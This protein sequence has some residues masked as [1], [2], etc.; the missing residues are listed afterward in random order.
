MGEKEKI[1]IDPPAKKSQEI[2]PDIKVRKDYEE[3]SA[4]TMSKESDEDLID[5]LEK[6]IGGD[7]YFNI[8]LEPI[9][10]KLSK[11]REYIIYL[12]IIAKSIPYGERE[13]FFH[14][15][16]PKMLDKFKNDKI[17]PDLIEFIKSFRERISS[18]DWNIIKKE[19][20]DKKLRK[21]LIQMAKDAT[22]NAYYLF[23]NLFE[24]LKDKFN[25][26]GYA[27]IKKTWLAGGNLQKHFKDYDF[28]PSYLSL[29]LN[30][31]KDDSL[32]PDLVRI[33]TAF[34]KDSNYFK[35]Q[36]TEILKHFNDSGFR[37]DLVKLIEL[38]GN[39]A[40]NIVEQFKYSSVS[41]VLLN[42][43][44]R[45]KAL[46]ITESLKDGYFVCSNFD[47]LEGVFA[48]AE[49]AQ[50]FLY[51]YGM[52]DSENRSFFFQKFNDCMLEDFKDAKFRKDI[53][54]MIEA[55]PKLAAYLVTST[56]PIIREKFKE[57]GYE[58][59]KKYWDDA[60]KIFQSLGKDVDN[61]ITRRYKGGPDIRSTFINGSSSNKIYFFSKTFEKDFLDDKSR[62]TLVKISEDLKEKSIR[63]FYESYET[64]RKGGMEELLSTV[65]HIKAILDQIDNNNRQ[66]TLESHSLNYSFGGRREEFNQEAYLSEISEASKILKIK[67]SNIFVLIE[68]FVGNKNTKLLDVLNN[69]YLKGNKDV[70]PF[71]AIYRAV[72]LVDRNKASSLIEL[73]GLEKFVSKYRDLPIKDKYLMVVQVAHQFQA[74]KV[75]LLESIDLTEE[76]IGKAFEEEKNGGG[77]KLNKVYYLILSAKLIGSEKLTKEIKSSI[78]FED[79]A[80]EKLSIEIF[81]LLDEFDFTDEQK[82]TLLK[83]FSIDI[84]DVNVLEDMRKRLTKISPGKADQFI[85]DKAKG[86]IEESVGKNNLEEKVR[87]VANWSSF[88]IGDKYTNDIYIYAANRM[89]DVIKRYCEKHECP[90]YAKWEIFDEKELKEIQIYQEKILEEKR[91]ELEEIR[92]ME[93]QKKEDSIEPLADWVLNTSVSPE[94]ASRINNTADLNVNLSLYMRFEEEGLEEQMDFI[95]EK[96][97]NYINRNQESLLT[98]IEWR[99]DKKTLKDV[100][101]DLQIHLFESKSGLTAKAKKIT[102][103]VSDP[104]Y[105]VNRGLQ[106]IKGAEELK[107]EMKL[108]KELHFS[109]EY[110]AKT[111]EYSSQAVRLKEDEMHDC[112]TP[113]TV[114]RGG[115]VEAIILKLDPKKGAK[116][117]FLVQVGSTSKGNIENILKNKHGNNLIADPVGAMVH[118]TDIPITM[119]FENGKPLNKKTTISGQR[120]GMVVFNQS[121]DMVILKKSEIHYSQLNKVAG[122]ASFEK[123]LENQIKDLE[124]EFLVRFKGEKI[125]P[126]I[127]LGENPDAMNEYKKL[128]EVRELFSEWKNGKPLNYASESSYLPQTLFWMIVRNSNLSGFIESLYVEDG[129]NMVKE[130]S[131][132]AHK[133]LL[134][135]FSDGTFGL[136]D[137]R[138][139]MQDDEV[140]EK[141]TQI[142]IDGV[143]VVKAVNLDTGSADNTRIYDKN[144]NSYQTGMTGNTIV[145]NR[146][147]IY[148]K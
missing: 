76:V 135:E 146:I 147:G 83:Q 99:G 22:P 52:I 34:D 6:E 111:K 148:Q 87:F 73:F 109:S 69:Y 122:L 2:Q 26:E 57:E 95:K 4:E 91:R 132:A 17:R 105:T 127:L 11:K 46:K 35:E 19:F 14:D 16:F 133:R 77:M 137:S 96:I 94:L 41:N 15:Q 39:N 82:I 12:T 74:K 89:K 79:V 33:L 142:K 117:D 139:A 32:S 143:K 116:F 13:S 81:S 93:N 53:I 101:P 130:R 128:F 40:N 45:T 30:E 113:Y 65:K 62:E 43:E 100:L 61:F 42:T 103:I 84:F 71:L 86:F 48:D 131:G 119:I 29:F 121:G 25:E 10:L 118:G 54:K 68:D 115:N 125:D 78:S 59:I 75:D 38:S 102:R 110:N 60:I 97:I 141:I 51:I 7:N 72:S 85:E 9:L 21:D 18:F 37:K 70:S 108:E 106:I 44:K 27:G 80:R 145:S 8:R 120:D 92:K 28:L 49:M 134:M 136:Y 126:K 24:N 144:S 107:G 138:V 58:G 5:Q 64:Q 98:K 47:L 55:E 3:T 66:K 23:A 124:E 104:S 140:S 123:K 129:K 112:V 67:D 1:N 114:T 90:D 63:F 31:L 88:K 50:D 56:Y 36:A 20:A